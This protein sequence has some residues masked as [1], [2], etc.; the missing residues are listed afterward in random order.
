MKIYI[1]ALALLAT[2]TASAKWGLESYYGKLR[3]SDGEYHCVYTNDGGTKD[4]KYVVFA[5]ERRVGKERD[6]TKQIRIDEV[7]E[8]GDTISAPSG[9]NAQYSGW[10]CKFLAR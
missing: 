9:L 8:S 7:V 6:F 1:A 4:F 5:M 10:Y 2:S 3:Y